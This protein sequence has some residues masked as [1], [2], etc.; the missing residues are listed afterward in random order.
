M[1]NNDAPA[2]SYSPLDHYIDAAMAGIYGVLYLI[3]IPAFIYFRHHE[4]IKSRGWVISVLQMTAALVDLVMRGISFEN[5][6]CPADTWRG[7]WLLPLWIYPYFGRVFVLWYHFNLQNILLLRQTKTLK[8]R[9]ILRIQARPWN[10]AVSSQVITFIL[11]LVLWTVVAMAL[12]FGQANQIEANCDVPFAFAINLFQGI[13]GLLLLLCAV[14]VLWGVNDAYLLKYEF[15]YLLGLGLPLFI[16]WALSSQLGWDGFA[17]NG[18][19]VDIIEII[20]ILGTI[21]FPL[22]GTKTFSRLL[23]KKINRSGNNSSEMQGSSASNVNDDVNFIINDDILLGKLK[24]Y[25]IQS[26]AVENLLFI[27]KA[28]EYRRLQTSDRAALAKIVLEEY[29]REGLCL[30]FPF[31]EAHSK[32]CWPEWPSL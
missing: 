6:T 13:V 19:W 8:G 18:F 4:P 32:M 29:I 25:L 24:Q 26:W 20:F 15:M 16:V 30:L 11:N 17:G 12:Y 22:Y 1:S 28:Q 5:T 2:V 9:L 21:Y 27:Q 31:I 3:G 14:F 7:L 23:V 10:T